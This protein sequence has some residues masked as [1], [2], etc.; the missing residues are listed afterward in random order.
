MTK[1]THAPIPPSTR[2]T[3]AASR[4]TLHDTMPWNPKADKWT[5]QPSAATTKD[6]TGHTRTQNETQDCN[7]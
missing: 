2:H 6:T 7:V 1:E 5:T 3:T 4:Y